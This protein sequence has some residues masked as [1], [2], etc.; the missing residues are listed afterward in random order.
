MEAIATRTRR[1]PVVQ[2]TALL[3]LLFIMIFIGLLTPDTAEDV[4]PPPTPPD[5]AKAQARRELLEDGSTPPD[6][7]HPNGLGTK[8]QKLFTANMY[9][10]F[11]N[12]R[13]EYR[14][15][16]LWAADSEVGLIRFR[17]K[18]ASGTSVVKTKLAEPLRLPTNEPVVDCSGLVL[19]KERIYQNCTAP[20]ERRLVIDC[21]RQSNHRY[22]CVETLSQNQEQRDREWRWQY[23]LELISTYDER[24]AH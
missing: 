15:T 19:T 14:E 8:L 24:F 5:D 6:T 18:L 13:L 12:D 10:G 23:E 11:S 4:T 20:F 17:S 9:Y 1:R 22:Q 16:S 3:D 2:L 7:P 21:K